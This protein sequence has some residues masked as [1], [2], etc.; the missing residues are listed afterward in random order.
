MNDSRCSFAILSAL[1]TVLLLGA[2]CKQESVSP[3]NHNPTI[4]SIVAFPDRVHS[5]DS[6]TVVCS[7]YDLDGD[8]LR[9]DWFCTS[10]ATIKGTVVPPYWELYNT[11]EN[12]AIFYAPDS[13]NTL[14]DSIRIDVDVRDLK[15]GG[16]S[17]HTFVSLSR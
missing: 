17:G 2:G 12:F 10:G 14:Q 3:M 6:L 7:A 16:K 15:G 11:K 1:S 8:S 13:T 4:T 5:L 9:Y